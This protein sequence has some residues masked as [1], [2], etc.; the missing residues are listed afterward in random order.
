[1]DNI[2]ECRCC[3]SR[4]VRTK[5]KMRDWRLLECRDCGF[6]FAHPLKGVFLDD[7][8]DNQYAVDSHHFY[9]EELM[10]LAR[11]RIKELMEFLGD[12]KELKVLDVGCGNG[13]FLQCC[14]YQGM[15]V[16]GLEIN[17]AAARYAWS[18]LGK[19]RGKI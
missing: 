4:S 11:I 7:T 18:E 1:M 9:R 12:L 15:R 6:V 16:Q 5:Y 17:E 2:A 3:Q 14:K 13:Y 8:V 19:S 10:L